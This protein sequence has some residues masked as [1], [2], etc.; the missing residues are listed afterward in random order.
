MI[1][2]GT[3]G[4]QARLEFF[5]GLYA[6]ALTESCFLCLLG[7]KTKRRPSASSLPALP[8]PPLFRRKWIHGQDLEPELGRAGGGREV[9]Q[10]LP[11]LRC[12]GSRTSK[13]GLLLTLSS[14]HLR[15]QCLRDV[16][17]VLVAAIE[18]TRLLEDTAGGGLLL[19]SQPH[20][21]VGTVILTPLLQR[22]TQRR[23]QSEAG[24][25]PGLRSPQVTAVSGPYAAPDTHAPGPP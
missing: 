9:G 3:L 21:G 19:P 10:P 18:G 23:Q 8:A 20:R 12:P 15:P 22:K 16:S 5:L 2:G 25:A 4:V 24:L 7:A 17:T 1:G 6:R 13:F 11:P 14:C